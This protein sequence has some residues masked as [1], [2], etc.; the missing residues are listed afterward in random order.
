MTTNTTSVQT[1][2]L[3]IM[4][5]SPNPRTY[6]VQIPFSQAPT[7]KQTPPETLTPPTTTTDQTL[8]IFTPSS[9]SNTTPSLKSNASLSIDHFKPPYLWSS[10]SPKDGSPRHVR[11][12]NSVL[13]KEYNP[14]DSLQEEQLS[15]EEDWNQTPNQLWTW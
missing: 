1:T 3:K 10:E 14:A 6:Q 7:P 4:E 15:H 9:C 8:A 11:F 2:F 13:I 12:H 5:F